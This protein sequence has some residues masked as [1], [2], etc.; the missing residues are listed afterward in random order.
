MTMAAATPSTSAA[1][2]WIT[3]F[4]AAIVSLQPQAAHACGGFFCQPQRPILQAGERIIF[5]VKESATAAS[6]NDVSMT[7]QIAYEGTSEKFG[8]VLPVPVNPKLSVAS[9]IVFAQLDELTKPIFDFTIDPS[10]SSTCDK[11][12]LNQFPCAGAG[13]VAEDAGSPQLTPRVVLLDQGSVGPFNYETIKAEQ[14]K[15][16][17]VFDWLVANGYDQPDEA[18]PLVN[19]YAGM[20][21]VFVGLKLKNDK[22]SGDIQPITMEYSMPSAGPIAC[23]PLQ[24]TGIAAVSDMPIEIWVLGPERV[25]PINYFHATMDSRSAIDWVNCVNATF[26]QECY[27]QSFRNN[28][29]RVLDSV[30]VQTSAFQGH[31]FATE[32]AGPTAPLKGKLELAIDGTVLEQQAT[33]LAYIQKMREFGVPNARVIQTIVEKY[34]PM[35]FSDDVPPVCFGLTEIYSIDAGTIAD[36]CLPFVEYEGSASFDPKAFTEEL[37]KEVESGSAAAEAMVQEHQYLSRL[38]AQ[39]DATQMTKDP[40]F[41]FSSTEP[42]VSRLHTAIGVPECDDSGVTSMTIKI[43]NRPGYSVPAFFGCGIWGS[44]GGN[45][46]SPIQELTIP[47][48]QDE[49]PRVLSPVALDDGTVVFSDSDLRDAILVMDDRVPSQTIP[50][51]EEACKK[52]SAVSS[53]G[54][55]L[56]SRYCVM[57]VSSL[58]GI[59][60]ISV[61]SAVL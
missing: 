31:A 20:D 58:V 23:V 3:A 19:Y 18:R 13:G 42:D 33:P 22:D 16:E 14:G 8:W 12:D 1:M 34:I 24:I 56:G 29:V 54:I 10:Q 47:G 37:E 53:F 35:T 4:I 38:Y 36:T 52:S 2:V 25:M 11:V 9:D 28:F 39:L 30:S 59:I 61:I 40:F 48:Y 26:P 5:S 7:V 49:Q 46:V 55:V 21:M 15:P 17:G 44:N 50:E 60:G 41:T 51:C 27:W 6:T 43:E 57:A 45:T 32:F